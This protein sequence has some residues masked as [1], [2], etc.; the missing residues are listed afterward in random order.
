VLP[1]L[2]SEKLTL[3][4]VSCG[5]QSLCVL[6]LSNFLKLIHA[7]LGMNER[8]GVAVAIYFMTLSPQGL[9]GL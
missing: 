1:F 9:I 6:F 5:L 4:T 2:I 8:S 7:R 3:K